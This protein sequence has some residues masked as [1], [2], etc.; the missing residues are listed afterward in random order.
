MKRGNAAKITG[1]MHMMKH[2][3]GVA[4][5]LA[6]A[7]CM[8][9]AAESACRD[10]REWVTS[11]HAAQQVPETQNAVPAGVSQDSTLREIVHLTSGGGEVRIRLSNAYGQSVMHLQTVHLAQAMSASSPEIRRGTDHVLQ[12]GGSTEVAIPA[13]AEYVSDP[14]A[15]AVSPGE[16]LTVSIYYMALPSIVTGHPGSRATSYFMRG[17]AVGDDSYHAALRAEHWYLLSTVEVNTRGATIVALGD[18]ITDGHGS[19]T[20]GNDRWT[21]ALAG[22]LQTAYATCSYGV[23]NAGIGGNHLLSDGL[24]PNALA[25]FDRDVLA[26]AGV[27]WVIVLEGVNDLGGLT[28]SV[29]ATPEAHRQLVKRILAAYD[30]L[31]ARAHAQGVKIIGAT[32]T[33]YAGSGYY[34]PDA[35]NEADRQAVNRWIRASGKFDDVIDFDAAVRDPEHE[36]R[37]LPAYDCGDHLHPSPSGYKA[38]ADAISLKIFEY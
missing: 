29:S 23:A 35:A 16:D 10:A 5:V 20:N 8:H 31:I 30:Q 19:T 21:D 33:P 4:W 11:W 3:Q 12:F 37:L 28:E 17:N 25:R 38:M 13:G 18:S 2:G 27:R 6:V 32:I 24:G 15:M 34:H 26:E 14:I 36:D 1:W 7:A 22:R 9:G